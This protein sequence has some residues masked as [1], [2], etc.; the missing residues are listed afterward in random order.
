MEV[1]CCTYVS[2]V[3]DYLPYSG[4]SD[5]GGDGCDGNAENSYIPLVV[6]LE[7]CTRDPLSPPP[8]PK[9]NFVPARCPTQ[10]SHPRFS[11]FLFRGVLRRAS[12]KDQ[13]PSLSFS[14]STSLS[15]LLCSKSMR[16][17]YTKRRVRRDLRA[18]E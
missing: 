6:C 4:G 8:G 7:E 1:P 2:I 16:W 11:L 9:A 5:D 14:S 17:F 10:I 18:F 13:V 12:F 3:L 15:L